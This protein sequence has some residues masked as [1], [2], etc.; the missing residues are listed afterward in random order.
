M[1]KYSLHYFFIKTT[2]AALAAAA[3][4]LAPAP[5]HADTSWVHGGNWSSWVGLV[6]NDIQ[7]PDGITSTTTIAQAQAAADTIAR[8]YISVGINFVRY[9]I[10]PATVSGNWSVTQAAINELIA[11]GMTVDIGCWYIDADSGGNGLIVNMSTWQAMWQTVDGVYHGNNAVYYEPINEPFGYTAAGLESVYS[12]FL[13]FITKSQ[14]HIIL[15][16]TGYSDNVTAIGG[17]SSFNNCLLSV[18]DY[19]MW[20]TGLTTE[21]GWETDLHNRVS[22][23]REPHD[24][25]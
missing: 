21:S 7:Y 25:D 23:Y 24:N 11:D 10:N 8:D 19:A 12:T 1:K 2:L 6:D 20:N 3:P 18:H 16:G 15:D 4:L 9:P 13:G 5:A 14:G 17:D 22:P